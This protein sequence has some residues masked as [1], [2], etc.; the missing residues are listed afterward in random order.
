MAVRREAGIASRRD[1]GCRGDNPYRT[2]GDR[3]R[4]DYHQCGSRA[5]LSGVHVFSSWTKDYRA[6]FL[7]SRVGAP[8]AAFLARW[9]PPPGAWHR[10]RPPRF[11]NHSVFGLT[12]VRVR[13]RGPSTHRWAFPIS[14]PFL[15]FLP[16]PIAHGNKSKEHTNKTQQ[17]GEAGTKATKRS[18]HQ[19][20]SGLGGGPAPHLV[21]AP[22]EGRPGGGEMGALAQGG[23]STGA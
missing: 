2:L 5:R 22:K 14:V 13:G 17:T 7:L 20:T 21:S 15:A 19:A 18:A 9:V 11:V 12:V 10:G 16:T 3:T 4:D 6:R 8:G 1:T 23:P